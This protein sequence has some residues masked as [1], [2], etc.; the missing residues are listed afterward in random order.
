MNIDQGEVEFKSA[1][2]QAYPAKLKDRL[3]RLNEAAEISLPELIQLDG[4]IALAFA[5]ATKKLLHGVDRSVVAIGSHGQTIFHMPEANIPGTLQLGNGSVIA[6]QTGIDTVCDFRSADM[7]CGGQ[8]APLTPAFNQAVFRSANPRVM[9]NLGGIAN[10]TLLDNVT[11]GFD[12]GP[13][14]T[15]L[16]AWIKAHKKLPYDADGAWARSGTCHQGLLSQMLADPYFAMQPPKST[17]PDYFN[18]S[19]LQT[20]LQTQL[21]TLPT[22]PSPE[23]VQATLLEL[24]ANSVARDILAHYPDGVEIILC[25]GGSHNS[26]LVSRLK[27]LCSGCTVTTTAA[28]FGM[29]VDHCESVAFAWFAY[30]YLANLPGNLPEVTG[31][32][33]TAILG[34]LHKAPR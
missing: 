7:A 18:L 26:Y 33:Q 24:T 17:G 25:G 13:A 5:G 31:A 2:T 1:I 34:A 22:P 16:D 9:V 11:L 32:S 21:Q 3:L 30:R 6:Q 20:Q 29:D 27:Q 23:D 28:A 8:G 14:N 10:V 15:L 4:E 12:T 19:W